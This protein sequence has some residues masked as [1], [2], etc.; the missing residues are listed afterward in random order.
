MGEGLK[1]FIAYFG[2]FTGIRILAKSRLIVL[3]SII[4]K[5]QKIGSLPF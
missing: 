5:Q 3:R 4:N 2:N 1:H